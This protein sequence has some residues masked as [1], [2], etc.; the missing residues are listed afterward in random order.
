MRPIRVPV[1]V[2]LAFLLILFFL[3]MGIH[4]SGNIVLEDSTETLEVVVLAGGGYRVDKLEVKEVKELQDLLM[5]YHGTLILRIPREAPYI[6][7]H[8]LMEILQA[9]LPGRVLIHE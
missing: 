7:V 9:G 4:L 3:V 1:M 5:D 8:P 6:E 2:D